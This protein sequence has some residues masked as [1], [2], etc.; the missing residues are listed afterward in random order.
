MGSQ[1]GTLG[2]RFTTVEGLLTE[3]R[4]QLHGQIF[5]VGDS[6]AG[7]SLSSGDK[8]KWT[9]F[10]SRLDAAIKGELKFVI[11]LEDPLAASYVQNLHLPDPDPQ[12]QV[13]EYTRTDEEEDDLG[14]KD[15]KTEG[16]EN[17]VEKKE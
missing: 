1:P 5:D 3:I 7:D 9:R 4:D 10:F 14:F 17:D 16:Y 13:E 15:M 2:G 12:L 11:T 6:G 8:E